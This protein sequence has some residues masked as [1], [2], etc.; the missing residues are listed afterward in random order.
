MLVSRARED[1]F[2]IGA[3]EVLGLVKFPFDWTIELLLFDS[4]ILSACILIP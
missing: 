2:M 1:D 4:F 3:L